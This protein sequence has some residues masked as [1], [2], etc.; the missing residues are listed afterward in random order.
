MKKTVALLLTVI[1]LTPL[2]ALAEDV[3]TPAVSN[4]T[5]NAVAESENVYKITAPYSGVMLPFDLESGDRVSAGDTM[6]SMD[7]VKVYAPVDGTVQAVFADPG[8]L[9]EDVTALY[10]M[11]ACIERTLPQVAN[12]STSGAY[13]DEDNRLIHVGETVYFYQTSDK[14]NEGEGRVT[15]VNGSDYTVE[16]TA[17]DFENGD[18]IKIYRDEKMGTKSCIGTGTIER[19]ADVAVNG[20][21]RVLS[22][23]VQPGQTVRKGQ[24][25]FELA[26]QDAQ[27]DVTSAAVTASHS[28]VV[29]LVGAA[30]GQQVYKGQL[31]A[32]IHDLSVMNVVAEVDE[33]D[34]ERVHVGDTLTVVFDCYPQEEVSGT[35][36]SVS[37]IGNAKQNATYYD[38]TISI[39]TSWQ[40]LPGM[41]ATVWLPA[42]Q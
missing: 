25:L 4:V 18:T 13:N 1:L 32:N 38:V 24:L 27:A 10:G 16:L 30:S 37:L 39:S 15:A 23:A 34:L 19:A 5:A 6:F 26:E 20:S 28:G 14:D 33:I 29:E 41:N 7:T 12:A 2:C 17:G 42:G 40:V 35:V 11:I 21:G 8:D 36:Q 3:Q 22:C 31:L 9:C